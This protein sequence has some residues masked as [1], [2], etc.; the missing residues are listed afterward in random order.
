MADLPEISTW[1]PGVYQIETTDPVVGGP[2][3]LGLG[4]GISNVPPQQLANRT[5]WLKNQIAALQASAVDQ[6]DIDAAIATLIGG[7]PLALD[8]LNELAAALADDENYAASITTALAGKLGTGDTAADSLKLGGQLAVN[9]PTME[10]GSLKTGFGAFGGAPAGPLEDWN[11]PANTH[12]GW[13]RYLMRGNNPNGPGPITYYYVM[14][15][16]YGSRDGTGNV[17]QIAYPYLN[18]T[19][20]GAD[21]KN[22]IYFRNRFQGVWGPWRRQLTDQDITPAASILAWVNFDGTGVVSIRDSFNVSSITD[23]GVGRYTINFATALASADYS[24][25]LTC[26]QYLSTS[27]DVAS[28]L[29]SGT[30]PATT[31]FDV[32]TG[33]YGSGALD[34][35][36]IFA[37][38]VG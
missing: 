5:L 11:D 17:F 1:E 20:V 8:T 2:P 21:E 36:Y 7:A 28:N 10:G 4:Q 19:G 37:T 24:I 31:G 34:V 35:D 22:S 18:S 32:A 29:T 38:V 25:A 13:S 16:E 15:A 6:A 30:I 9:I 12:S 14:N 23:L 3:D 27:Y 26:S 33:R